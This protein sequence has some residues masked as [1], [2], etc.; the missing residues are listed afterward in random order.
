MTSPNPAIVC[1]LE[2][3]RGY[4]RVL[5]AAVLAPRYQGKV[6]LSGVVQWTLYEAAKSPSFGWLDDR[7]QCRAYLRTLLGRNL[8]DEV[9]KFQTERRDVAREQSLQHLLDDTN[10]RL[11]AILASPELSPSQVL[12][13]NEQ[14]LQVTLALTHLP[15]AQ[16]QALI[17]RY[18][19]QASITDIAV[20]LNRTTDAVAGLLKR[21]LKELRL[22][23][24]RREFE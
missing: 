14:L 21:G 7:D 5:A 12:S 3:Y 23:L 22:L 13:K 9:R 17:L 19:Q 2:E 24:D 10:L 20:A 18:L 8:T 6:D 11:E 1:R 4:L 15:D 16:R